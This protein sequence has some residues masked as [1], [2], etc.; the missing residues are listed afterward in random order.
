MKKVLI[1]N[2]L[3]NCFGAIIPAL[4][5]LISVPVLIRN[6]GAEN[7][8]LL[9]LVLALVGY[10]SILD[11]NLT[12]GATRFI[13]EFDSK[14][15][16]KSSNEIISLG[17]MIYLLIGFGGMLLIWGFSPLLIN[18]VFIV[19]V[20][21]IDVALSVLKIAAVSFLF[22]QIQAFLISIPQAMQRYSLSS[23]VE[24]FFGSIAPFSSMVVSVLG[25]GIEE[26]VLIRLVVSVVNVFILVFF[27]YKLRPKFSFGL[28][29]KQLRGKVFSF[30]V[31]SYLSSIAAV[32]YA[33]ADKLILGTI[34]NLQS[35]TL[36]SIPATL[37][38]RIFSMTYRL[39]SVVYPAASVLN[40][41]GDQGKLKKLY[42]NSSKYLAIINLYIVGVF[43]I[44]GK[45][46]L[47]FWVGP[48]FVK[49]GYPIMV[50]ILLSMLFDSLT[51]LPSL[52]N[53]AVAHPRLTGIFAISRAV[54]SLGI[55]S[56]ATYYYGIAG[57]AFG[58]LFV[59]GIASMLFLAYVH[60]R[61]IPV[62]LSQ[63]FVYSF[64][65]VA[66][67]I[68]VA[69]LIGLLTRPEYPASLFFLMVHGLFF[70]F[71]YFFFIFRFVLDKSL[72][73]SIYQISKKYI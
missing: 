23:L 24:C 67:Y 73:N 4:A 18:E 28:C 61:A 20:E 13:S 3:L 39:G 43:I 53:N 30:S 26:I 1:R 19:P 54:V 21:S 7:Y 6:L 62:T 70:S 58:H 36:F 33:Q 35:I 66:I 52:I 25:Y 38:N 5:N 16:I 14:G 31:Y 29:D 46:L 56:L 41:L 11:V 64:K 2:S 47:R 44:Y 65:P 40:T 34:L 42:L 17:L 50:F 10:F 72:K 22:S 68:L 69:M 51:N 49:S 63:L 71:I 60:G 55:L 27:L 57:T 8:G 45:D 59:S 32:T 12:Q 15:N 37:I 9:T 48:Q